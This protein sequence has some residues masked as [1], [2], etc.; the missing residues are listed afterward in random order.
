VSG[1]FLRNLL[2]LAGAYWLAEW[3][4]SLIVASEAAIG[5]GYAARAASASSGC[6]SVRL[7][8]ALSLPLAV[9]R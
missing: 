5:I 4:A 8:R 3:L 2:V 6:T 9:R 1:R 7:H